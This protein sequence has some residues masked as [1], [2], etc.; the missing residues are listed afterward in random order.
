MKEFNLKRAKEGYK[1]QTKDGRPVR[2]LCF[3]RRCIYCIVALIDNGLV[4]EA[5]KEYN[6]IGMLYDNGVEDPLDLVMVTVKK[7]GWVNIYPSETPEVSASIS[8]AFPTKKMA[9][10]NAKENC[11]ETLKI[12]WDEYVKENMPEL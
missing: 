6:D 5:I 8:D 12:N 3:D 2:I 9:E 10:E 4:G 1:V 7:E 11:I